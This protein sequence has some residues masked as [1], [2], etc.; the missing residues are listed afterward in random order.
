MMEKEKNEMEKLRDEVNGLSWKLS[1]LENHYIHL[2]TT[3]R[4][5]L[6]KLGDKVKFIEQK[7]DYEWI[8]IDYNDANFDKH[9]SSY[10]YNV[11]NGVSFNIHAAQS[12]G[13][14]RYRIQLE[15]L[16]E[17]TKI[18]YEDEIELIGEKINKENDS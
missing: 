4:P 10:D 8:I 9:F 6:F 18:V 12:K 1:S 14:Y 7:S 13:P 2:F 17:I 16:N 5:P 15:G 3:I 11:K